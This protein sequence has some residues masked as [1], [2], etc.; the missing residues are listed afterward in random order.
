MA[1]IRRNTLMNHIQPHPVLAI[2]FSTFHLFFLVI[3][4]F[5]QRTCYTPLRIKKIKKPEHPSH[6]EQADKNRP[7]TNS[8]L[9]QR[10]H[11]PALF[12]RLHS[13]SAQT[14]YTY[15]PEPINRQYPKIP[16]FSKSIVLQHS[17]RTKKRTH[18][19]A[20][21]HHK[22]VTSVQITKIRSHDKVFF[23]SDFLNRNNG[24]TFS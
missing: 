1:R 15:S 7:L 21:Y 8:T 16:S 5:R 22:K 6:N 24:S 9:V 2:R 4:Q 3:Y 10:P 13:S 19:Y 23:G 17:H 11:G 12:G 20:P 18:T 14:R